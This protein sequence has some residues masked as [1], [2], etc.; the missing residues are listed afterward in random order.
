[1]IVTTPDLRLYKPKLPLYVSV[2]WFRL[3]LKYCKNHDYFFLKHLGFSDIYDEFMKTKADKSR[4]YTRVFGNGKRINYDDG[5]RRIL[6]D[7]DIIQN[8]PRIFLFG[9][10]MSANPMMPD[11]STIGTYIQGFYGS[12]YRVLSRGNDGASIN[13]VMREQTFRKGDTVV[14]FTSFRDKNIERYETNIL[15]LTECYINTKKLWKHIADTA[16]HCD[17]V[18]TNKVA[19][20]IWDRINRTGKN[21]P[22]EKQNIGDEFHLGPSKKR[23]PNINMVKADVSGFIVGI[24]DLLEKKQIRGKERGCIVM[25]CNPFTLGHRYLI[26]TAAKRV[27]ILFVFVVEEDKSYF[28]F[29]DRIN[30]VKEGVKD[31]SNVLVFPSG[32]YMISSTTL[33]QYFDKKHLGNIQVSATE[34]LQL[35]AII[36]EKLNIKVRFAGEEPKDGFTR[37]YNDAMR[38]TL[39]RYGI[40]F[41][42]IP[43][44]KVKS[45]NAVISATDVRKYIEEG[46]RKEAE[47]LLPESTIELL[48]KKGYLEK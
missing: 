42:E 36:A 12:N 37:N 48:I 24:M 28:K 34:D 41:I 38:I 39:P 10:C 29:E 27:D 19:K 23:C 8:T 17:S 15:S 7:K 6:S 47:N 18:I 40:K 30:M 1:M 46:N 14:L 45:K 16:F 32:N 25:N 33:P 2:A 21:N 20:T 13:L 31:I 5:F 26:E 35:F 11:E 4:G 3:I 44:K 43:R 22:F 9:F